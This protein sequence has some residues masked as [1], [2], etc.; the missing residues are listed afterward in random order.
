M[1]SFEQLLQDDDIHI[2]EEAIGRLHG[3]TDKAVLEMVAA[4]QANR[5]ASL[6]MSYRRFLV[7]A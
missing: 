4:F 1:N 3:A 5:R 7:T 6:A 2:S